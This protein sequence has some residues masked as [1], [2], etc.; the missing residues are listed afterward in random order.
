MPILEQ[1]ASLFGSIVMDMTKRSGISSLL[2]WSSAP[3][4]PVNQKLF[5]GGVLCCALSSHWQIVLVFSVFEDGGT[6]F[7]NKSIG[8]VV[9]S[10]GGLSNDHD[11]NG[12]AYW[13]QDNES[14]SF[15]ILS[16]CR[17]DD[18]SICVVACSLGRLNNN[19]NN[20]VKIR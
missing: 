15:I 11:N 5:F 20:V 19:L 3:L 17:L 7:D 18:K 10:L 6:Y 9:H 13:E 4:G 8:I 2:P 1:N 12:A 16:L 14:I